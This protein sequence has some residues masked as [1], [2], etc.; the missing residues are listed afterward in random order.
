MITFVT[1]NMTGVVKHQALQT[2]TT[3]VLDL[4]GQR[5]DGVCCRLYPLANRPS[6]TKRFKLK[7]ESSVKLG[8]GVQGVAMRKREYRP[9]AERVKQVALD[10]RS[11]KTALNTLHHGRSTSLTNYQG[12]IMRF[13]VAVLGHSGFNRNIFNA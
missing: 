5:L 11:K 3:L 2:P 4:D 7:S 6:K 1:E 10:T 12:L 9:G 8:E 13:G